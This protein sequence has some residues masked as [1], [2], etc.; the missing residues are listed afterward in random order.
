MK[1]RM[2]DAAGEVEIFLDTY[3][4]PRQQLEKSVASLRQ[5]MK[6]CQQ[7][8]V[9]LKMM[10]GNYRPR[11]LPCDLYNFGTSLSSGRRLFRQVFS[12]MWAKLDTVACEMILENALSNAF[13]HGCPQ[14]PGVSFRISVDAPRDDS[15]E[16]QVVFRVTN[17][18]H[19]DRP[20]LT[21][22]YIQSLIRQV[23]TEFSRCV[24]VL[25]DQVGLSHCFAIAKT[26][27]FALS[28]TEEDGLV[29]FETRVIAER[30][31]PPAHHTG[32]A[33]HVTA[34]PSRSVSRPLPTGLRIH[35]V[36]DSGVARRLVTHQL[37]SLAA[38]RTVTTFGETADEVQE[39]VESSLNRA[40]IVILDEHLEYRNASYT[41]TKLMEQLVARGFQGLLCA[42][43]ANSS[44]AE[45]EMYT[46]SGAK[47]ILHKDMSG[48]EM[49]QT[50]AKAYRQLQATRPPPSPPALPGPTGSS[51]T[52]V[53]DYEA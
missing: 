11:M 24:P 42:R 35:V 36:D 23:P 1:N 41:G 21:D 45:V 33:C 28:L 51:D 25:S 30:M 31:E 44:E 9:Y 20:R 27:G 13:K 12:K 5:G 7:R 6:L 4:G 18:S 39:V 26:C 10:A 47:C 29:A 3:Q 34:G 16:V 32:P 53:L 38:P 48:P 14:D 2:A 22:D 17:R 15:P 50:I 37:I 52:A 43:S 8:Q 40:D 19:P 49:V 46:R